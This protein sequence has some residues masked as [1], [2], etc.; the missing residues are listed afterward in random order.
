MSFSQIPT[1]DLSQAR[2]AE[3]KPQFLKD[4]RR[5]ILEV[6]FLYISNTGIDPALVESV[7]RQA[8]L[9]FALPREKKL[10]IQMQREKS[11]LGMSRRLL[12]CILLCI[13]RQ[14]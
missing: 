4:L 12:L 9:F 14:N 11:F 3:T 10:E 1:L 5:A 8:H 2:N 13:S 7:I 6:G